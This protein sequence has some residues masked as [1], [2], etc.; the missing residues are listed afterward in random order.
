MAIDDGNIFG[1]APR[2][3]AA[4]FHEIGQALDDLSVDQLDERIALLQAEIGR[5]EEARKAKRASL[6]AAAAFFKK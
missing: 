2:R 5:L 6:E 4:S 3:R 1:A